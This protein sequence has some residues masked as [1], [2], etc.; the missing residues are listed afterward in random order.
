MET[1]R[2]PCDTTSPSLP[3]ELS[4]SSSSTQST[5]PNAMQGEQPTASLLGAASATSSASSPS[6][7]SASSTFLPKAPKANLLRWCHKRKAELLQCC[8]EAKRTQHG[9][10][11]ADL[12]FQLDLLSLRYEDLGEGADALDLCQLVL[13]LRKEVYGK[14]HLQV[15]KSMERISRLRQ[16]LACGAGAEANGTHE[17]ANRKENDKEEK[18]EEHAKAKEARDE[19]EENNDESDPYLNAAMAIRM[20][21]F[22]S[23]SA[24]GS[25]SAEESKDV[26]DKTQHR[27]L[28]LQPKMQYNIVSHQEDPTK[29][30]NCLNVLPYGSNH[31]AVLE[32]GVKRK[33]ALLRRARGG[34]SGGKAKLSSR[35][36]SL[37]VAD[38]EM[39]NGLSSSRNQAQESISTAT[40]EAT[41]K[42]NG[43]K[44]RKAKRRNP[45]CGKVDEKENNIEE[46]DDILLRPNAP[47][48]PRL[49]ATDRSGSKRK[50][51]VLTSTA[52]SKEISSSDPLKQPHPTKKQKTVPIPSETPIP[53]RRSGRVRRV[54]AI[55]AT[56]EM[57]TDFSRASAREE[58]KEK[59]VNNKKQKEEKNVPKS[60]TSSASKNSGKIHSANNMDTKAKGNAITKTNAKTKLTVKSKDKDK[61]K[62]KAKDKTKSKGKTGPTNTKLKNKRKIQLPIKKRVIPKTPKSK[63]K[64]KRK[65][66]MEEEAEEGKEQEEEEE[67]PSMLP[68]EEIV[69]EGCGSGEHDEELVLCDKCNGGWHL[70]CMSIPLTVIPEGDWFCHKCDTDKTPTENNNNANVTPEEPTPQTVKRKTKR[71]GGNRWRPKRKRKVASDSPLAPSSPFPLTT[72]QTTE[73]EPPTNT[74][75]TTST[76]PQNQQPL[77]PHEGKDTAILDT[78]IIPSSPT[79]AATAGAEEQQCNSTTTTTNIIAGAGASVATHMTIAGTVDTNTDTTALSL[80]PSTQTSTASSSSPSQVTQSSASRTSPSSFFAATTAAAATALASF[81]SFSFSS[82]SPSSVDTSAEDTAHA[83][84]RLEAA[85]Q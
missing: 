79:A 7:A 6:L 36:R 70:W 61:D 27:L 2:R 51:P 85:E 69:C 45:K 23:G 66:E 21:L 80:S 29:L 73:T 50:S 75:E 56:P 39:S 4:P 22:G 32:F 49:G 25:G 77:P 62:A 76:T 17:N 28:S 1:D 5:T 38:R 74:T 81:S 3:Q 47:P 20:K 18:A 34:K 64:A 24:G 83:G 14:H 58:K 35:L 43:G 78:A 59:A 84:E 13:A 60:R 37:K 42:S 55:L 72:D 10:W 54:S 48:S 12:S 82:P 30:G 33:K 19:V 8:D 57:Q 15:A 40:T 44:E 71:K 63:Y 46:E 65:K 9:G 53:S 41:P 11:L 68:V 67:T 31:V 52:T 16:T 26:E